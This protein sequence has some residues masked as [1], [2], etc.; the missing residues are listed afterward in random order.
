MRTCNELGL[1]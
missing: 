1:F